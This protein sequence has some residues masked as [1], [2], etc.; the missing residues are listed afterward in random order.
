MLWK[1]QPGSKRPSPFFTVRRGR[2]V[3]VFHK[4]SDCKASVVG[5]KD[6]VFRGFDTLEDAEYA[7][8]HGWSD[9]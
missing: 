7:L 6:A 1:K 2:S 4:W 8:C 9:L 3:G 5:L